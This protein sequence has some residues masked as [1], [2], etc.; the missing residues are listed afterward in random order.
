MS[1]VDGPLRPEGLYV[2][3]DMCETCIFRPGNLM[4][5]RSGR[6]R[7]MIDESIAG[8]ACIP[9]HKTLDGRRAVCR[10]FWDRHKQ[11]TLMCRLGVKLGIIEINPDKEHNGSA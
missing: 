1:N 3:E 10:G 6:V 9:C 5:L 7:G 11:D 2:C 4:S 8:D